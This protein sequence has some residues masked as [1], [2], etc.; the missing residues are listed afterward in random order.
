MYHQ[1]HERASPRVLTVERGVLMRSTRRTFVILA[2]IVSVMAV[3]LVSARAGGAPPIAVADSYTVTGGSYLWGSV[4]DGENVLVNDTDP[5]N[6]DLYAE[7]VSAPTHAESFALQADGSLTFHPAP[8]YLGTD[9]FTYRVSDG[10]SWSE[11]VAVTIT[12]EANLAPVAQDDEFSVHVDREKHQAGYPLLVGANDNDPNG[13]FMTPRVADATTVHGT[14]TEHGDQLMY[15]PDEGW[16]GT[17]T[18]TYYQQDPGGL[19]SNMA[20]VTVTH[21]DDPPVANDDTY[22]CPAGTLQFYVEGQLWPGYLRNDYDPDGEHLHVTSIAAA[23]HGTF[24]TSVSP[25]GHTDGTFRY[26]PDPGFVGT[27]TISYV[28]KDAY[29]ESQP[30]TITIVVR[31]GNVP[32]IAAPDFFTAT[33]DEA[34]VIAAPGYLGNDIDPD[35][36]R[37]IALVSGTYHG[38]APW[39][40]DTPPMHGSLETTRDGSFAYTP[41]ADFS[42]TDSFKYTAW[43]G[44]AW[45]EST[46]V[47]IDVQPAND[48]P[49]AGA[50]PGFGQL[51]PPIR[52]PW[53]EAWDYPTVR[54]VASDVAI[55][56]ETA[57]MAQYS[58][59]VSMRTRLWVLDAN[60]QGWRTLASATQLGAG[61]YET[62]SNFAREV[63]VETDTIVAGTPRGVYMSVQAG[64]VRRWMRSGESWQEQDILY[65]PADD[66]Q[67]NDYFGGSVDLAD[68]G[69]LAVGAAMDDEAGSNAGAAYVYA[70]IGAEPQKV[71]ADDPAANGWFGYRVSLDGDLLVVGAPTSSGSGAAYVLRRVDGTWQQEAKLVPSSGEAFDRFGYQ[72]DA[73]GDTIVVGAEGYDTDGLSNSGMACVFKKGATGWS[74]VAT[75]TA[76]T[77]S[78]T[79]YFGRSVAIDANVIVVG[80]PGANGEVGAVFTYDAGTY[81]PLERIVPRESAQDDDFG[82]SVALDGGHMIA[83]ATGLPSLGSVAG[84]RTMPGAAFMFGFTPP[85]AVD[86]LNATTIPAPGLLGNDWDIDGDSLSVQIVSQP[87]HG[88]VVAYPNGAYTYTPDGTY[89]SGPDTFTYRLHDGT[90]FS[91]PATATVMVQD[92]ADPEPLPPIIPIAGATRFATAVA[93]SLEAY[94]NGLVLTGARTVVIATG[95]NWPDALGGSSL[96][97]VLDCPI[98]LVDTAS[99]PG[100]VA[101]EIDRLEATDA[102]ILGGRSAVAES[103]FAAL[104]LQLGD[105]NVDRI[106]GDSRYETAD[107]IAQRVIDLQGPGYDGTAFVAT[108]GKFPDALGAAPLA[109]A[110]GWPLYLVNPLTGISEGT[111]LAMDKVTDVLV[112]GGTSAVSADVYDELAASSASIER[113]TGDDRYDTA[114][115][116]A[117]WGVNHAGLGWNRVAIATGVNFPDALAGG[118]FQGRVRSVMLLTG[119]TALN[120]RTGAALTA[121]KADITTVTFFGGTKALPS[122]VRDQVGAALE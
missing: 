82:D 40:L 73:A 57:V 92:L 79:A 84:P 65:A 88:T 7:I 13:D 72:L 2:L 69:S 52:V 110:N 51:M 85:Q 114:V 76:P 116:I 117:T 36:D 103:V 101:D 109:T 108:G 20:T 95:R 48:T 58:S 64:V 50:D 102:I 93:A 54:G 68:G 21:V 97:G 38:G 87:V 75:L 55:D 59:D 28:V 112:L 47:T 78:A 62:G 11:P 6:D 27:E 39:V 98:L 77:P 42:G 70:E 56:G 115:T 120:S 4:G 111:R 44:F 46:T 12:I 66:R 5:E 30:A 105:G 15:R 37:V 31:D 41:E 113:L 99:V 19:V 18:F 49:I 107:L 23:Q 86:A 61:V 94:P 119:P 17:D 45:S 10:L 25:E 118:V 1:P 43:D 63:D 14:V 29:F 60:D 100:D 3:G 24:F 67:A 121:H 71:V 91:E 81:E 34:L 35:G 22:F 53:L 106:A 96:A 26:S 74:Q 89:E 83:G 90:V 32:P 8:G 80:V 104:E 122:V 16:A 9:T 33:E